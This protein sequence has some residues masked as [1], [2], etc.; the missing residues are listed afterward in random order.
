MSKVKS[1]DKDFLHDN[2]KADGK[3]KKIC[4]V[5]NTRVLN[6]EPGLFVSATTQQRAVS[7]SD[8]KLP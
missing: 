5:Q 8:Q 6:A 2:N 1:S 3:K 4:G 7:Q